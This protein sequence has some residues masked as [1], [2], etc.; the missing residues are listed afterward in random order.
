MDILTTILSYALLMVIYLGILAL[1]ITLFFLIAR[2]LATR[3]PR[4]L[5][6]RFDEVGTPLITPL[7]DVTQR[8]GR[9]PY[10]ECFFWISLALGIGR[11]IL[12]SIM[13][14]MTTVS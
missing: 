5:F 7:F 11:F 8:I 9:V 2:F 3:W 10:Y 4:P 12:L 13:Q 14:S 1:D 6:N